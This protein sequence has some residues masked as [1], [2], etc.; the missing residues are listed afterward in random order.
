[1]TTAKR[2]VFGVIALYL[3][4][5]ILTAI[6]EATGTW[7]RCGCEADCWCKRPGLAVF[8]WVTPKR[9]HHGRNPGDKAELFQARETD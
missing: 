6:A 5:A 8:R 7:R 9:A 3:V 1:M 2:V 4:T